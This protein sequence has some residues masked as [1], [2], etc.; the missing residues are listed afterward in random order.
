MIAA[1]PRQLRRRTSPL[2]AAM[3]ITHPKKK[4]N[5]LQKIWF[6]CIVV[7]VLVMVYGIVRYPSAPIRYRNGGYFD[8]AGHQF[9][10]T[11]FRSFTIWERCLFGSFIL[12]GGLSIPVVLR[13][14]KNRKR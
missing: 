14:R 10:E 8:K 2:S 11:Q 12:A 4:R 5:L 3:A 9:T 6:G 7:C 1:P 13:A